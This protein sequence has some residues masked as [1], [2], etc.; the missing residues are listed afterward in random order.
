MKKAKAF[1]CH[2]HLRCLYL[3]CTLFLTANVAWA[4]SFTLDAGNGS[5]VGRILQLFMVVAVLGVAPILVM[6]L[7]SFTRLVV[8]FSF[9]RTALGIQQT[10]PNIVL[11]ALALFLTIFIMQPTFDAIYDTSLKPLMENKILETDAATKAMDPL[12]TFMLA[13]VR[14]DDL[15]LFFELGKTEA[16]PKAE[17]TPLRILMPAFMVSELRRAFEIGFLVCVPFLVID[18]V[19][20]SILMGMGMMML[21][22]VVVSMPL[23]LIFFVLMDGWNLLCTHLVRGFH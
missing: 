19:V 15:K 17:E 1:F 3:L 13:N 23:K 5:L 11:N 18:M 14:E 21:P 4:E 7:T 16:P 22:P 8:V 20:S 6:T 9:L 10:P 12:R 2:T